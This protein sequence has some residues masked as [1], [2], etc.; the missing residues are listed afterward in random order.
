LEPFVLAA[1]AI[2][3]FC[4]GIVKGVVG[5]GLPLTSIA[6]MTTVLDLRLAVPLLVVPI[7]ATNFLQAIRGGRL[8]EL[9]RQYWL[10]LVTAAFGVWAGAALLYRIELSYLLITLG[11]VVAAYSLINLSALRLSVSEK[12]MPVLSPIVGFLSGI[13]AGTTG[14]I[15][16]PVAIY[17]QALGMVKDVFVQ[18]VGIQFLITGSI[19]A[20]ALIYEGGLNTETLPVSTLAMVP[21]FLGMAAGQ[22]V[23]DRVSEDRFRTWMW[24]FM[25]VIGLN[26]IRKGLF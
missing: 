6:L 4:G 16:V 24:I 23:R 7:L 15:G 10:M 19:M 2:A 5:M 9:L 18:A 1:V 17:Y 12:S 8:V 26:L 21:A 13:L 14:S 3:F 25:I 20:L 11:I 22:W